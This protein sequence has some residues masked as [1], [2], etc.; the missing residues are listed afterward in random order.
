MTKLSEEFTYLDWRGQRPDA[1][2]M[3]IVYPDGTL[4][5][6]GPDTDVAGGKGAQIV[7]MSKKLPPEKKTQDKIS[8]LAAGLDEQSA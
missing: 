6:P 7:H 3:M 2:I 8:P 5:F 1:I 4:R